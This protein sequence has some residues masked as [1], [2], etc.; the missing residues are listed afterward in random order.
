MKLMGILLHEMKLKR[1]IDRLIDHLKYLQPFTVDD[2]GEKAAAP[3]DL[4]SLAVV[5]L[6][7]SGG[8]L[9]LWQCG[10]SGGALCQHHQE[11]ADAPW[12][13]V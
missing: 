7:V 5:A 10:P 3:N 9:Y 11:E 6:Q 4:C 13:S 1:M 2:R 12:G 8:V